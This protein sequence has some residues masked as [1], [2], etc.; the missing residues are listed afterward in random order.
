MWS[1][2]KISFL[3]SDVLS[4]YS[5]GLGK[6]FFFFLGKK[7][8]FNTFYEV[9]DYNELLLQLYLFINKYYY[10]INICRL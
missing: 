2:T 6:V 3:A 9:H 5:L 4:V 7:K 10:S 1:E 8:T